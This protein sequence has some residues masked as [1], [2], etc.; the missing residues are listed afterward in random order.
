M[1]DESIREP[2]KARRA[3]EAIEFVPKR[4]LD[5]AQQQIEKQQREIERLQQEVERLRRELEVALRASKRQAAP[6]SRAENPRPTRSGR[7]VSQAGDY[8]QQAC[9]PIPARV[10]ELSRIA[11]AA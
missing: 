11:A 4:E 6:H 5:R 7:A 8:G 10:D 1:V 2:A 9:R 3:A